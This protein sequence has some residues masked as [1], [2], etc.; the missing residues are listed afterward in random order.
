MC[1]PGP[2]LDCGMDARAT[3]SRASFAPTAAATYEQ[4]CVPAT[5][6]DEDAAGLLVAP[7]PCSSIT[8][9]LPVALSIHPRGLPPQTGL[10]TDKDSAEEDGGG[11]DADAPPKKKRRKSGTKGGGKGGKKS[12]AVAAAK[13]AK[14]KAG[15]K[16]KSRSASPAKAL[17]ASTP[18][19]RLKR[20]RTSPEG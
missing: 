19:G 17:A 4:M 8:A 14:A 10:L 20:R 12:A 2:A 5:N 9:A 7:R 13:A 6:A 15:V 1:A 16:G 11:S 18:S 3:L